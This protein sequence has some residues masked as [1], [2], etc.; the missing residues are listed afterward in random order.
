[1]DIRRLHLQSTVATKRKHNKSS[2]PTSQATNKY[3]KIRARLASSDQTFKNAN[4][5]LW[6]LKARLIDANFPFWT[7]R[8]NGS[9]LN[10]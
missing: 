8:A 4:R 1:M 6:I 2:F 5:H 9:Q 3:K 7:E 10:K